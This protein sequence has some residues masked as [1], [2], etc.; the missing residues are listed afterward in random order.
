MSV[1]LVAG[2]TDLVREGGPA[3]I[4]YGFTSNSDIPLPSTGEYGQCDIL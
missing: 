4:G 2:E 3:I 1:S